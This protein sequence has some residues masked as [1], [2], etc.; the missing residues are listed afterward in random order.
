MRL[1]NILVACL[2]A[3]MPLAAQNSTR[4]DVELQRAIQ[5][6]IVDGDL[7]G[8]MEAFRR[9]AA[10]TA[11][12]GVAAKAL[13][14][15]AECHEKLGSAEAKKTYRELLRRYPDGQEAVVAR[16]RM[17][18]SNQAKTS[19]VVRKLWDG[20]RYGNTGSP[21]PDGRYLSFTRWV[22]N[23]ELGVLD[24][25]T[26]QDWDVTKRPG[27][28]NTMAMNGIFSPDSSELAYSWWGP[29]DK[30]ELRIVPRTGGAPRT[31]FKAESGQVIP[32]A[33]TNDK[34]WILASIRPSNRL[35]WIAV[36]DGSV[37]EL[38]TMGFHKSTG[39]ATLS[40]D[41]SSAPHLVGSDCIHTGWCVFRLIHV[42]M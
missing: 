36:A 8:A 23:A 38:T 14:H 32:Y 30:N 35:A 33:W 5:K 18:G 12:P 34:R 39:G 25:V 29:D 11:E 13:L 1:S 16:Q 37:T 17:A 24:T 31:I 40:P 2:L 4:A 10:R 20:S 9:L 7:R 6:E 15:L 28:E 27:A 26:G 19:L 21:S 3:A 22:P 41:G 42:V